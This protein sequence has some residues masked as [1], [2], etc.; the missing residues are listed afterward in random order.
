MV[1]KVAHKTTTQRRLAP[2]SSGGSDRLPTVEAAALRLNASKGLQGSEAT[3][4]A[5]TASD[6]PVLAGA[7]VYRNP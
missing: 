6:G 2:K 4:K 7:K 5:F 1:S 3:R